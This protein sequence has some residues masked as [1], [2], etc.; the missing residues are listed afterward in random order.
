MMIAKSI[1]THGSA[2]GAAGAGAGA[3]AV[4]LITVRV[5]DVV[6]PAASVAVMVNVFAPPTKLTVLLK[7]PPTTGTDLPFIL[8]VTPV[9][10]PT[11]PLSSMLA[12]DVVN[13]HPVAV[14]VAPRAGDILTVGV[15]V[16]MVKDQLVLVE[17]L[18]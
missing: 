17:F 7:L 1:S 13:F 3:G 2:L 15:V 9:A 18:A 12:N 16:S 6:L 11:E 10:S 14:S 8:T 4:V 5:R